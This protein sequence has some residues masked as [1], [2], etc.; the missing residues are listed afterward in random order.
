MTLEQ[1]RRS[2]VESDEDAALANAYDRAVM[3]TIPMTTA[4]FLAT[5]LAN[6]TMMHGHSAVSHNSLA[7]V[8]RTSPR[9]IGKAI[10]EL[11]DNGF[12][13]YEGRAADGAPIYKAIW[14][15]A[16]SH[17]VWE[18]SQREARADAL[19]T[20]SDFVPPAYPKWEPSIDN[21]AA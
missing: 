16:E 19:R 18:E 5:R 7:K 1:F 8:C 2:Y 12:A 6:A 11:I 9:K 10:Q 13:R 3:E 21:H 17:R 14:G 15:R 4:W 20:N